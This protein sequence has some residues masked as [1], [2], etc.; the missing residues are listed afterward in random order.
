MKEEEGKKPAQEIYIHPHISILAQY[1][2]SCIIFTAVTRLD[3]IRCMVRS[4]PLGISGQILD[5]ECKD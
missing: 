1:N 2:K 4:S 3:L 5:A